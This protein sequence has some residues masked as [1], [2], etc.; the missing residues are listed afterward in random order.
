MREP[1]LGEMLRCA[2][3]GGEV[4]PI[5]KG[6]MAY[7]K[8][9]PTKRRNKLYNERADCFESYDGCEDGAPYEWR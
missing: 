6:W 9:L 2:V 1:K 8:S 4:N 7:F 5:D 3:C